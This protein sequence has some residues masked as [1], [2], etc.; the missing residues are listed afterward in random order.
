MARSSS[1]CRGYGST[2]SVRRLPMKSS[3]TKLGSFQSFSRAS[4]ATSSASISSRFLPF[5]LII[6]VDM[7]V[8]PLSFPHSEGIIPQGKPLV[9]ER[10]VYPA[11][12][13]RTRFQREMALRRLD[14]AAA[15]GRI[16]G[17]LEQPGYG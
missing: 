2:M 8:L 9:E 6:A 13:R 11:I 3:A 1:G 12:G 5:S 7:A 16:A 10:I 14:A 4:S 17:K 15:D